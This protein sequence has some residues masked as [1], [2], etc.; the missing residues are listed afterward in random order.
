MNKRKVDDSMNEIK[1]NHR[2]PKDRNIDQ[3]ALTRSYYTVYEVAE[4]LKFHHQTIR[5]MIRAGELPAKK[6]GKEWRIKKEDLEVFTAPN[7]AQ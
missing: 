3:D 6:L 7:N 4:L 2:P 5:R 1:P